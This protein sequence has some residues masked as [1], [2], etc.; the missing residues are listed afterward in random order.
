MY[1]RANEWGYQRNSDGLTEAPV[2]SMDSGLECSPTTLG[3]VSATGAEDLIIAAPRRALSLPGNRPRS[4]PGPA[5]FFER[6]IGRAIEEPP[7]RATIPGRVP[8]L[9]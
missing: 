4:W 3:T 2:C 5:R 9:L 1:R 6:R 8:Q 7:A